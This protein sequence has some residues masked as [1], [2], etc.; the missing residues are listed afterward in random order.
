MSYYVSEVDNSNLRLKL[1]NSAYVSW[2]IVSKVIASDDGKTVYGDNIG[3][4]GWTRK[5]FTKQ[6]YIDSCQ[7]SFKVT[8][9]GTYLVCGL[10]EINNTSVDQNDIN[11]GFYISA[12][13]LYYIE[14]G[15]SVAFAGKTVTETDTLNIVYDGSYVIYYLNNV[16]LREIDRAKGNPLYGVVAFNT[17][18]A[19]INDVN[20]SLFPDLSYGSFSALRSDA[21]FTIYLNNFTED[22]D[23]YRITN[24]G[25]NSSNEYSLAAMKYSYEKFNFVEKDEY[26]DESQNNKKEIIFSTDNYISPAFTDAQIQ[27][28]F[29]QGVLFNKDINYLTSI[30]SDYD[31]SFSIDNETLDSGFTENKF[32]E[33]KIDFVALFSSGSLSANAKVYGL[34]CIITKDGKTL[35]FKILRSQAKFIN[36]FL[37][38]I[39]LNRFSFSPPYSIDF[40]AF[41]ENMK[42]IN[43]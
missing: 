16:K 15:T 43:V 18:Y 26:I 14:N 7:I 19:R 36:L 42:L 11:Y 25:E 8:F 41:D 5:A 30:N 17:P 10:S 21:S 34:Y 31:Y 29:T 37:G 12:G 23:L 27:A 20:F 24:I 39:P 33:L 28:F 9:S 40:Y 13:S 2:N 22:G 1:I 3:P 4:S 32:K 35:K 38:E 6:S